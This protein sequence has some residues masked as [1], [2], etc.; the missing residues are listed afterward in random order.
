MIN[1]KGQYPD[2]LW[3]AKEAYIAPVPEPW[4]E[5]FTED[6][7]AIYYNKKTK[8]KSINHPLDNY[9][10]DL[11]K[12]EKAKKVHMNNINIQDGVYNEYEDENI[13][14]EEN[15]G[16]HKSLQDEYKNKIQVMI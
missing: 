7:D 2:L 12:A 4:E 15:I 6:G 13:D 11:Y 9:Y 10:R 16:E 14:N 5:Q 3:I 1:C 8:T